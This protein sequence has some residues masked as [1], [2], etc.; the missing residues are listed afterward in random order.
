M[1]RHPGV[2]V[3]GTIIIVTL[4]IALLAPVL[5]PMDPYATN[6]A[7]QLLPPGTPGH[8]LGTDELG[9][10][11]ASRLVYGARL[12]LGIGLLAALIASGT[13]LLLGTLT[14]F[15]G[16][17][18]DTVVMRIMDIMLSF[19]YILLAIVIVAV[20][21][22]GLLNTLLAVAVLG[23][24]FYVRVVR[25]SVLTIREQEYVL[26]ARL[27]GCSNAR[28][29]RR[30]IVPNVLSPVI[31]AFSLDVG[32]LILEAASLSFLGLGAQP[33]TAEW[34]AMLA[35]SRQYFILAPHVAL[36]PGICIFLLV[37]GCNLLGDGL[38]DAL[39]PRLRVR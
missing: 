3:G 23:I 15:F 39:D 12:S 21:G 33:P 22:P 25:A 24:P 37:L 31:T 17:W 32:W 16:G 11:M 35:S 4:A 28:M 10:D 1:M 29:M 7:R 2:L 36:L 14:G 6:P 34:G 19:P 27:I 30:T 18:L 26:A 9:R 38:R 8:I 13:G 5:A 20:I